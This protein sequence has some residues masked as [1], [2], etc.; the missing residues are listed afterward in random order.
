[1]SQTSMVMAVLA[2][3]AGSEL[4]NQVANSLGYEHADIVIGGPADAA[5]AIVGRTQPPTYIILDIGERSMDVLPEIDVLAEHCP[6]GTGVV[7]IGGTNDVTFSRELRNRGVLEYFM[8][9][10][11]VHDIRA[12]FLSGDAPASNEK[13]GTVISFMSAASGDGASTV[14][15]NTAFAVGNLF[16]KKVVL[17][18]MDYQWGMIAKNLDLTTP[19]GIRELFDHP[20]RGIDHTL[21]E[22]MLANYGDYLKI[23]AA[24]NDLRTLP[25][26]SPEIIRDLILTLKA[27]YDYVFI[28][29]PH[30]WT[31]W[32]SSAINNSDRCV[33]VAQLWLRSVTHSARLLRVWKE[34]GISDK[35]ST[36]I[37]NRSGAKYKE[38]VSARDFERV[39]DKS[40]GFYLGNDIK[41]VVAAENQG[42]TIMEVGSSLLERQFKE[43]ASVFA[44]EEEAGSGKKAGRGGLSSLLGLR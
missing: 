28:D 15:L 38:A 27:E 6:Y 8:R 9:P 23:I 32:L 20:D 11:Q 19:F 14:A 10:A 29:L 2:D 41:T 40:V 1:M 21:V 25:T 26:V 16:K 12:A 5:Q 36:V 17:I 18:D 39:C 44:K 24:P 37:I 42:K 43:L 22:R 7:V 13:S 34:I 3:E 31:S 30:I 35:Q 4:A 33:L